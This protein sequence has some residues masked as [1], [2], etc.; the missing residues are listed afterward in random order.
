MFESMDAA[1]A[2]Y[3]SP[4]YLEARK[5]GD[6]YGRLRISTPTDGL[7]LESVRDALLLELDG[8]NK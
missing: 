4:A 5:I 7:R 1:R 8:A 2:A 6:Q 3:T